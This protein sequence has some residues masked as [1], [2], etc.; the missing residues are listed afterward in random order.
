[1][2]KQQKEKETRPKAQARQI[3]HIAGDKPDDGKEYLH[4]N[5]GFN[6]AADTKYEIYW[7]L[8][9]T[10]IK[11]D[12]IAL[13]EECQDRYDCSL[14]DMIE[15]GIRQLT[16]RPDYKIVGFTD[17]GILKDN[18][19]AAMQA[20]ADNYKVGARAAGEGIKSKATKLDNMV[21][22]YGAGSQEELEAKLARMEQLEKKGLI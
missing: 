15:S 8:P 1:M 7:P 14:V 5:I 13:S 18:G 17:D 21:A 10:G 2:A 4:T 16:T 19:H 11:D 6:R 22:K 20:M 9:V 3:E 12:L